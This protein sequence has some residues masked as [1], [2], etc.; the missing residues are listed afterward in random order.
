MPEVKPTTPANT[1]DVERHLAVWLGDLSKA[2]LTVAVAGRLLG[3]GQ[4]NTAARQWLIFATAALRL[5]DEQCRHRSQ[6]IDWALEQAPRM[7]W[8]GM[9]DVPCGAR[10]ALPLILLRLSFRFARQVGSAVAPAL[11][12]RWSYR[13]FLRKHLP[14]PVWR[15]LCTRAP[16]RVRPGWYVSPTEKSEPATIEVHQNAERL[17]IEGMRVRPHAFVA[18]SCT[19]Q[20]LE[21]NHHR[22]AQLVVMRTTDGR[23]T[24]GPHIDTIVEDNTEFPF[25]PHATSAEAPKAS[26]RCSVHTVGDGLAWSDWPQVHRTYQACGGQS[27]SFTT[28]LFRVKIQGQVCCYDLIGKTAWEA[29]WSN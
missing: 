14:T 13:R 10:L 21:L 18:R 2:A 22:V 25:W 24:E 6:A 15:E 4:C 19:G 12:G 7:C 1:R 23:V 9:A 17:N 5:A 29:D 28:G 8:E 27:W 26:H 3:L 11:L 16:R 20:P